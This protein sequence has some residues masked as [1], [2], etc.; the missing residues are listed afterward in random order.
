MADIIGQ[1][2]LPAELKVDN[3]DESFQD[4]AQRAVDE[5]KSSVTEAIDNIVQSGSTDQLRGYAN[6]AMG[7]T[8][9]ALGM[10]VQS[11]ELAMAGIA[12]S[13]LGE[14][15]K[16]VGEAKLAAEQAEQDQIIMNQAE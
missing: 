8:K 13:A 3:A 5:V 15:Q 7:K 4:Q 10:A 11:P 2:A 1:P 14:V 6:D 12:Q 9:L 16:F